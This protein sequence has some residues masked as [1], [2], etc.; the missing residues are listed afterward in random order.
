MDMCVRPHCE[1]QELVIYEKEILFMIGG[2]TSLCTE[3]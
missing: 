3:L 1:E 2:A